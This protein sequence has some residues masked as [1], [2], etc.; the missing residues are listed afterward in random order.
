MSREPREGN[1][2]YGSLSAVHYGETWVEAEAYC[3]P[4]GGFYRRA[5]VRFPDGK[6][7]IVRCGIADTWFSIPVRKSDAD[8]YI[9]V[10]SD[11]NGVTEFRFQPHVKPGEQS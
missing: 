3:Y 4:N 10:A 8:G 11:D 9:F 7:R 2:I 1:C 5:R 6:L